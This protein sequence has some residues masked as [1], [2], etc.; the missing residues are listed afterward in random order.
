MRDIYLSLWVALKARVGI[1]WRTPAPA[2]ARYVLDHLV[3]NV[4]LV[5][6]AVVVIHHGHQSIMDNVNRLRMG[7]NVYPK[8]S[9]RAHHV[10]YNHPRVLLL[11]DNV[12]GSDWRSDLLDNDL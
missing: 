5:R 10:R 12:R 11:V 8:R 7:E 6:I 1:V 9:Y 4:H 3:D 2:Y